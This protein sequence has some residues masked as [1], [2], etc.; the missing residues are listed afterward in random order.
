MKPD[1]K[2]KIVRTTA[3]YIG[4]VALGMSFAS[5]GPTLIGLARNTNSSLDGISWLFFT[6]AA[7]YSISSLLGGRLYDRF[8]GH[9]LM[10]G[11]LGV[12]VVTMATIPLFSR[13]SFLAAV[14][15]VRGL[16]S[17]ATDVGG[18]TL[19]VWV[20]GDRSGPWLNLLHFFFGTGGLLAPVVVA[21]SLL[22]SGDIATAYRAIAVFVLP[23]CIWTACIKSPGISAAPGEPELRSSRVKVTAIFTLF[24]FLHVGV[25]ASFSG[26]IST[27]AIERGLLNEARAAYL[28]S[29]FWAALTA[30]RLAGVPV[31]SHAA[32]SRILTVNL[33]GCLVAAA[34][35]FLLPDSRAVLWLGTVLM[36]FSMASMFPVSI[37]FA[38]GFMH[39]TGSVM[40]LFLVGANVGSMVVPWVIG[41]LFE[42]WGGGVLNG[43]I[44]V[45]VIASFGVLALL[46]AKQ[47]RATD[48]KARGKGR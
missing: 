7:G 9:P 26:W 15:F 21:Q 37:I 14:F 29:I 2:R 40:G 17:G 12:I 18:N 4:F 44:I 28:A 31:S 34:L 39:I 45:L 3:Y 19:L 11:S 24:F 42:R 27:Y 46:H 35:L 38:G 13:L 41:Q 32:P 10:A 23:V 43:F 16:A 22:L 1:R 20:H 48:D 5:L 33:C 6:H 47:K 8:D 25:Q 36:G 30:G